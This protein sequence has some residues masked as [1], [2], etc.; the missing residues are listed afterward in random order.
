LR[1]VEPALRI[2]TNSSISRYATAAN[3]KQK[4]VAAA[5]SGTGRV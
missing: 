1:I 5:A 3:R 4:S 2:P